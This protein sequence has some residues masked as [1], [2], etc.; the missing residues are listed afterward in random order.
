MIQ[1]NRICDLQRRTESSCDAVLIQSFVN[2][3]YLTGFCSSA[4]MLLITHHQTFFLVD[5]RYI[6]A[7]QKHFAGS[8][9]QVLLTE[10]PE[11]VI[12]QLI[13]Q[14]KLTRLG[15]ETRQMSFSAVQLLKQQIRPC[16]LLTDD[17]VSIA[18]EELRMIKDAG[19]LA[20]LREAQQITDYAFHKCL[21]IIRPGVSE[22]D[23]MIKMGVEMAR[24]G[25]E[26]RSFN[27]ILT[28]GTQT[29]LPHGDPTIR[30]VEYGDFVMM[31]VGAM[32]NGYAADMTRTVA[33]GTVTQL[34]KEVYDTVLQ[35]QK[36]AFEALGPGKRCCDIDEIARSYIDQSEWAGKFGHGLGH[37]LGLEIH[38]QP[39]LRPGCETVLRPGMMTTV[40]PGIYL[41]GQFGVRIEDMVVI[42][43]DGCENM[44]GSPKQLLVL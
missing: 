4:G 16:E 3:R 11:Q 42:T 2:R 15:T 34:Q 28:S 7:A 22:L 18:L 35:A 40:E 41:P 6:E 12:L 39:R 17:T 23:I 29:A 44:T 36:L 31:D 27:M 19:E 33:V 26:K 13:K 24:Q 37:S 20:S 1:M 10:T 5:S 32:V 14:Y 21:E 30:Q 25:C 8:P 9:V 43:E 38:E